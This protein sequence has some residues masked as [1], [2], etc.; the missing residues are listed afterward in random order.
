MIGAFIG[1]YNLK[2]PRILFIILKPVTGS[3]LIKCAI[4]CKS[5]TGKYLKS[6]YLL[7]INLYY[8]KSVGR[9]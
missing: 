7:K 3:K 6:A 4:F 1:I 9:K 5:L 2:I 8:N